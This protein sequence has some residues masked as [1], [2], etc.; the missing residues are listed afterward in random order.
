VGGNAAQ[1]YIKL[2]DGHSK[3]FIMFHYHIM[4]SLVLH[5][6]VL[7]QFP[8]KSPIVG[9]TLSYFQTYS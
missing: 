1:M 6:R 5:L 7:L 2:M 4:I 3:Q 9:T 8:L